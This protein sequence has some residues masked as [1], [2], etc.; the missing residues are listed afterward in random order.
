MQETSRSI[1][2]YRWVICALLFFATTIN[3]TDRAVLGVVEPTLRASI[4]D[5]TATKYGLINSA[6]MVAYAVGSLGAGFLMDA[7]GVRLGLTLS[8]VLWSVTAAAHALA[9]NATQF[10]L[11]R[12][13]LGLGE[14]GNF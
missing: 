2:S 14:S 3:Y 8:L 4:P 6:F 9:S 1:G 7:I 10:A 5:W 11:I 13:A 12:F